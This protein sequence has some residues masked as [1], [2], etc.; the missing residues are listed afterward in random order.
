MGDREFIGNAVANYMFSIYENNKEMT[1]LLKRLFNDHPIVCFSRLTDK[2]SIASLNH[3]LSDYLW[4]G[5][6]FRDYIWDGIFHTIELNND[7]NRKRP[8][9]LKV[10]GKMELV[11]PAEQFELLLCERYK[12][13]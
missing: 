4:D 5:Y 3:T 13:R 7:I 10:G 8:F 12:D 2:S 11:I 9:P 1:R 6:W